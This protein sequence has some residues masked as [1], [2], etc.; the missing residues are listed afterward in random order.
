MCQHAFFVSFY[1]DLE[2]HI[3][4]TTCSYMDIKYH[5]S[6]IH[7]LL[8]CV[9]SFCWII[10]QSCRL[11]QLFFLSN[12]QSS[13]NAITCH[14]LYIM[15]IK[16]C[17]NK[18][19]CSASY[20]HTIIVTLVGVKYCTIALKSGWGLIVIQ[21]YLNQDTFYNWHLDISLFYRFYPVIDFYI[22]LPY[23]GW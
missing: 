13:F 18:L 9:G 1:L 3:I 10:I 20:V 15:L 5:F 2:E 23:F 19:I 8:L 22:N 11:L 7:P 4:L 21:I 16:M 17:C 6:Q 12:I 14:I